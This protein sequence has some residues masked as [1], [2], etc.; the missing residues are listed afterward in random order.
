MQGRRIQVLISICAAALA[1]S[2][3]LAGAQVVLH[4]GW[5]TGT[6]AAIPAGWS[7][8]T[9]QVPGFGPSDPPRPVDA[10]VNDQFSITLGIGPDG[11]EAGATLA[12]DHPSAVSRAVRR[13]TRFRPSVLHIS[14]D[15]PASALTRAQEI[16]ADS[17]RAHVVPL[18]D[19]VWGIADDTQPGAP[20][21]QVIRQ[22][23]HGMAFATATRL[24]SRLG[25]GDPDWAPVDTALRELAGS[26]DGFLGPDPALL[27]TSGNTAGL[28]ALAAAYRASRGATRFTITRVVTPPGRVP[29]FKEVLFHDQ[30]RR[31]HGTAYS[32]RPPAGIPVGAPL[33]PGS[34]FRVRDVFRGGRFFSWEPLRRPGGCFFRSTRRFPAHMRFVKLFAADLIAESDEPGSIQSWPDG[35]GTFFLPPALILDPERV[36]Q[37]YNIV[38]KPVEL[39]GGK[40]R[41]QYLW[42]TH[43]GRMHIVVRVAGGRIEAI[44]TERLDQTGKVVAS[45]SIRIAYTVSPALA[46]VRPVCSR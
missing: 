27:D 9:I 22:T 16:A 32:L 36:A 19:G 28:A 35:F 2:P 34:R 26:I 43:T 14:F 1:A 33:A 45:Q 24:A 23:S 21:V 39:I 31:I 29:P 25:T 12:N 6:V 17:F 44:R 18:G 5:Q 7:Q 42:T 10:I 13:V 8:Q 11:A 38:F 46:A 30:A 20:I 41:I 4:D 37:A 15:P 3:G 40:T